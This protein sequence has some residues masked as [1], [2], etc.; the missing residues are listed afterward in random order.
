MRVSLAFS[1]ARRLPQ[2][3]NML[4]FAFHSTCKFF[5]ELRDQGPT[6]TPLSKKPETA[7][8]QVSMPRQLGSWQL[9]KEIK[10]R[11]V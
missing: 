1:K 9:G 8:S 3:L 6:Q 4:A 5:D 2:N 11:T 7:V 10:F